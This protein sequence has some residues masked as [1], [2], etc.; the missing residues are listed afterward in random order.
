MNQT[1]TF[2]LIAWLVVAFLLFQQWQTPAVSPA[3]SPANT[4]AP[5]PAANPNTAAS[6]G[7]PALP[8]AAG[9]APATA[10]TTQALEVARAPVEIVTDVL[11]LQVDLKGVSI[12]DAEL[13]KYPKEKIAG[14]P[15]VVLLNDQPNTLYIAESGWLTQTHTAEPNHNALFETADGKREYRLADG[16]TSLSV[17]F[18]WR[19]ASGV[20]LTKTLKL[21]RGSYSIGVDQ[22]LRNGGTTPW[23][24]FAYEQLKRLPPPPPPKH[25]GFTNPEAFSFVGAAWYGDTDKYEKIK[26]ANYLDDGVLQSPN[27]VLSNGWFGMLEHHFVTIWVP[28]K[29]DNQTV[30]I[31]TEGNPAQAFH[32]VRGMAA[33]TVVPPGASIRRESALWVGP[34]AQEGMTSVHPTLDLSV[35]YGIFSFLSKPLFWLLSQLHTLLGN[36]GWAIIAIVIILKAL[37]FPLSAKQY[38]SAAKMRAVQPRLEALKERFG[39]DRQKMATAQMEL[40]KKEKINPVSGCLPTLIPIPI[41]LALYWVLIESVELRQAP[42]I[43]WIQN[44]TAPDPYFIL[45]VIN[46]VVMFLTQRLTPMPNMDPLQKKMLTFMPLI[47]GVMMAFF[48]SGLVLYWVVNGMLGLAQQWYMT[49]KYHPK[50]AHA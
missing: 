23:T 40:F 16:Q 6:S 37:L 35:D 39:D 28:G 34:K 2:L 49:K 22:E 25:A 14:S 30:S 4:T 11:R 38:E 50:T 24:G 1:R 32:I 10:P 8:A 29:G 17:P 44:L 19:D 12:V 42:W 13:L 43:G 15:N 47:F 18:V 5:V 20:L 3:A 21:T 36:W 9:T 41:F 46:L 7:M 45:P 33:Q 31:A 48:P 27:K 26:F